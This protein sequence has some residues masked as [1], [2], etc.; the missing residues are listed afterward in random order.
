MTVTQR[1]GANITLGDVAEVGFAPEPAFGDSRVQGD[2]DVLVSLGSQYGANTL[3][4]TRAVETAL[5]SLEPAM[6]AQGIE[7]IRPCIGPRT[8]SK[9]H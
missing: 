4:V 7:C 9:W 1:D 2:P 3:E 5:K 6:S 8:S